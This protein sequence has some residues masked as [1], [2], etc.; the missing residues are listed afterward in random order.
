MLLV[1]LLLNIFKEIF[2]LFFLPLS[3]HLSLSVRIL[4]SPTKP[5]AAEKMYHDELKAMMPAQF[6]E[7]EEEETPYTGIIF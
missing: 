2:W 7:E 4:S 1:L 5:Q 3:I 6:V